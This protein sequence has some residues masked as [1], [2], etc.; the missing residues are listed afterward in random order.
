[1]IVSLAVNPHIRCVLALGKKL[2]L[3]KRLGEYLYLL[4]LSIFR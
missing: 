2:K 1:M 4:T 3:L